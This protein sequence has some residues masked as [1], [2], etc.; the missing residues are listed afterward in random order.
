MVNSCSY[1]LWE[2]GDTSVKV[3]TGFCENGHTESIRGPQDLKIQ[4]TPKH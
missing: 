2:V 4:K 3:T 1:E